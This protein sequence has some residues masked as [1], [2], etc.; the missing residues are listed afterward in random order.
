MVII[1]I[2]EGFFSGGLM[3]M[4]FQKQPCHVSFKKPQSLHN[5]CI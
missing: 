4:T 3:G 2:I 5:L 1:I